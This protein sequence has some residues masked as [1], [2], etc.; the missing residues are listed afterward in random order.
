MLSGA[1]RGPMPGDKAG[2]GQMAMTYP[3]ARSE[4]EWRRLPTPEQYE[5]MRGQGTEAPGKPPGSRA[6]RKP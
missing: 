4:A 1:C 3:V 2:N 6:P 5:I